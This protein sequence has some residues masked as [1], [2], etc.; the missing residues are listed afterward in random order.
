M[1]IVIGSTDEYHSK[2]IYDKLVSQ[3]EKVAYLDT[4]NI[5]KNFVSSWHASNNSVDGNINLNGQKINFN[6]IKSIYWRWHH[7]ISVSP[8]SQ[9]HEDRFVSSMIERE[10]TCYV[11]SLFTDLD[12]LW[13][14]SLNAI[15][16]HK[17]KV[18]QLH[19]MAKNQI[20]VP[21][22]LITND[23]EELKLF[24]DSYDGDLIFKPVRGGAN[25]ELFD[26]KT[27]NEE[28]INNL[29]FCPV[30]FQEKL[31]GVDVRVYGVGDKLFTAEIRTSELDFRNDPN[32]QLVSVDLPDSVKND[33]L[34][35]MKMFDLHFTAIDLR[36]NLEKNEYVFIEANP[37]PMFTHFEKLTGFP[38][39][40][41]LVEL[42]IRGK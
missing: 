2:Y 28:K 32:A 33:C 5:P 18:H 9:S 40:D 24:I 19:E 7:G 23:K 10:F 13:V 4:R 38:I 20:R 17:T 25:T 36:Y 12:C 26:K 31:E 21:K 1:I 6:D 39:S 16:L 15:N 11:D 3:D 8:N 37:S 27:F 34:K 14:N 22:T 29:Q 42:L 41:N 30:T 35:I